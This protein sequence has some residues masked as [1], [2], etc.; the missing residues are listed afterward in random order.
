MN[1]WCPDCNSEEFEVL[2]GQTDFTRQGYISSFWLC[3]CSHCGCQFKIYHT[4]KLDPYY[5][6]VQKIEE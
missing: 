5:S 1:E 2:D 3:K 4:Y 6:F